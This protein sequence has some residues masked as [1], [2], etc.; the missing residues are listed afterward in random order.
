MKEKRV[1]ID[2][3]VIVSGLIAG[4]APQRILSSWI[5]G[6]FVVL[7]SK[8]LKLEVN[9]VMRRTKIVPFDAKRKNLLGTLFNQ[10]LMVLPKRIDKVTFT[11]KND[12]FLLELAVTGNAVA[13]VTGDKA[14]LKM[15]RVSGIELLSPERFCAKF[16]V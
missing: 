1:V 16:K 4:G 9:D 8:E 12:H 13:I 6:H 2:T 11:D 15:K 5:M 10:A 3:N 7:V 14:L